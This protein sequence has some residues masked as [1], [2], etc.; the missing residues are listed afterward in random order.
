MNALVILAI[1]AFVGV[2]VYDTEIKN[3]K[4]ISLK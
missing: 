1:W 2:Y 4:N 3:K